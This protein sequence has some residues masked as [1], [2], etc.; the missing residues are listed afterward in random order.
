M[1]VPV[2]ALS[3]ST[4]PSVLLVAVRVEVHSG[5][6][7]VISGFVRVLVGILVVF[8]LL[9]LHHFTNLKKEPQKISICTSL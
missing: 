3:V 4:P 1:S 5:L 7:L 2:S 9:K 8:V 6:V